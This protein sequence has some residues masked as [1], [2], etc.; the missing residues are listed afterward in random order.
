[1]GLSGARAAVKQLLHEGKAR[2][3]ASPELSVRLGEEALFSNGGEIPI[4]TTMENFGRVQKHVEWKSY[5]TSVKIKPESVDT[6]LLHSTVSIEMSDLNQGQSV[7]GIPALSRRRLST[8]VN[9]VD[10][11][12]V[13]LSGLVRQVD[14]L[15]EDGLPVL[16]HLPLLSGLF[17]SEARTFESQ[18]IVM[19]MTLTM[20]TSMD[21]IARWEAFEEKF[22]K[23]IP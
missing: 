8:K 10:G 16:R 4:P 13:L 23:A 3:L 12:T 21:T 11:E 22:R 19:A 9:S 1:L 5:G 20:A 15:Q 18:E 6:Y 17:A 2:L 14:S 7:G